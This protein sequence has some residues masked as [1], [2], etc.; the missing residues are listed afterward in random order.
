MLGAAGRRWRGKERE[1][2]PHSDRPEQAGHRG[3]FRSA[4]NNNNKMVQWGLLFKGA[5]FQEMLEPLTLPA[6]T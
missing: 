2:T 6:P 1:L 3:S 4:S 5:T